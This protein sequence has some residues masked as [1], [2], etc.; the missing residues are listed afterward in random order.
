MRSDKSYSNVTFTKRVDHDGG[1]HRPPRAASEPRTCTGCGAAY[2]HRRWVAA[3]NPRAIAIASSP[4]AI[5]TMCPACRSLA[6]VPMGYLHVDGPFFTEHQEEVERLIDREAERALEDN[7][8]GRIV[9]RARIT[10]GE[11]VVAT[12]TEH[13]AQR[14]GHALHKAYSGTV[15]YRFS[16]ENKLTRVTW[17]RD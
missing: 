13:L 12:T 7:P 14:L 3:T 11:L 2:V 1:R 6:S 16:H 15:T 4:I 17:H 8:L 10:P 9:S 5:K